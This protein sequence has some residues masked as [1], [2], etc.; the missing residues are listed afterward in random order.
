MLE[1]PAQRVEN[2]RIARPPPQRLD[3]THGA[4]RE[5]AGLRTQEPRLPLH[6]ERERE[7]AM[8]QQAEA[9]AHLGRAAE[10]ASVH[11]DLRPRGGGKAR[12]THR[13]R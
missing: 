13:A 5:E 10:L 9:P 3:E 12:E 7:G 2:F 4:A 6:V 11:H 1:A 8:L